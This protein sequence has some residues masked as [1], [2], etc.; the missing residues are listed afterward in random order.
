MDPQHWFLP[1]RFRLRFRFH[2]TVPEELNQWQWQ[3][4]KL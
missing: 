2:N 4:R 3:R 1:F